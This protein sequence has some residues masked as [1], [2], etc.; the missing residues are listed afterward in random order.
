MARTKKTPRSLSMYRTFTRNYNY[1]VTAITLLTRQMSTR[2]PRMRIASN[3]SLFFNKV[4]A[5]DYKKEA[6]K[7]VG[8]QWVKALTKWLNIIEERRKYLEKKEHYAYL[9]SLESVMDKSGSVSEAA[10]RY[11]E[12]DKVQKKIKRLSSVTAGVNAIFKKV[13]KYINTEMILKPQ[14]YEFLK[15]NNPDAFLLT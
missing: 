8:D 13:R 6:I 7:F 15:F 9:K 1:R 4:S 12:F 11:S 3:T 2:T 10:I 5:N 14:F